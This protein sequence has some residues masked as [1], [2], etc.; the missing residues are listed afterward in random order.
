MLE[1]LIIHSITC[2]AFYLLFIEFLGVKRTIGL[3]ILI[4]V[5][6]EFMDMSDG[7]PFGWMDFTGD[8]LGILFGYLINRKWIL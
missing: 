7:N 5:Y 3:V 4:A 8:C 2:F 1:D 6:K